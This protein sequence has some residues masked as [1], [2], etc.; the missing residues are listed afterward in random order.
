[1]LYNKFQYINLWFD[2]S[3]LCL[4]LDSWL[5]VRAVLVFRHIQK[6]AT[7]SFVMFVCPSVLYPFSW[8]SFPPTEWIFLKFDILVFFE[9]LLTKF[10]FHYKLTR[11]T[12][13][14]QEDQYTFLI[15]SHSVLRRVRNV[16]REISEKIKT[17]I[18]CS[19]T[20]LQKSFH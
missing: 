2:Y 9:N 12:G 3:F 13:T 6:I 16:S 15:I 17:K 11:L 4:A 8:N 14:L 10:K 18:L 20:F 5:L 19:I 7:V 1:M